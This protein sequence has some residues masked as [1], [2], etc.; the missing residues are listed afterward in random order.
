MKSQKP[1]CPLHGIMFKV[2]SGMNEDYYRCLEYDCTEERI[3][4]AKSE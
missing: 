1:T 2:R 4:E 3:I